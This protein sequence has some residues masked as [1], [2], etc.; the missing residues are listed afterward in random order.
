MFPK[1]ISSTV[2][3]YFLFF[4]LKIPKKLK[5]F[6]IFRKVLIN[7][8]L[9]NILKDKILRYIIIRMSIVKLPSF[10]DGVRTYNGEIY[11][12]DPSA[13]SIDIS[14]LQDFRDKVLDTIDNLNAQVC[15]DIKNEIN[16]SIEK[17]TMYKPF[18]EQRKSFESRINLILRDYDDTTKLKYED[19][20][21][22]AK[23][24]FT[25]VNKKSTK[26]I[27]DNKDSIF[28]I[29]DEIIESESNKLKERRKAVNN[30]YYKKR[31]ELFNIPDKTA[32][33]E[34]ER[35][36]NKRLANQKYREKQKK[37]VDEVKEEVIVDEKEKK[38]EYNRTYYS[39]QKLLKDK[40][41]ELEEKLSQKND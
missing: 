17:K 16:R 29:L 30:K 1:T 7:Y 23:A 33:T 18:V 36:E 22:Q 27:W 24:F 4:F 10:K 11:E 41:K 34:E 28:D 5:I 32:M 13:Y 39:K 6:E 35:K 31:K 9:R 19:E 3:S 15:D 40:I 26:F 21:K 38:K 12:I 2:L 8:L 14:S 20:I 25:E 37:N